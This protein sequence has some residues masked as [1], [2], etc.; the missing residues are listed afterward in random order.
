MGGHV[1]LREMRNSL[2]KFNRKTRKGETI[3]ET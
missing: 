3:W 1:A 2:R